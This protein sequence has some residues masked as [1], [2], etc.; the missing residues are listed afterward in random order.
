MNKNITL[1]SIIL[2]ALLGFAV[3]FNSINGKF[4]WDD[5]DLIENNAFIK[6]FSNVTNIFT[7][8]IKI[9]AGREWGFYR[10]IQMLTYM[11]DY[12]LWKLDVRGYHLTNIFLHVFAALAVFWLIN[13]LYDDWLLSSLAGIL[14]V[15]C[16]VHTEAVSYISG[17][18]DSLSLLF[19]LLCFIFY[20][21]KRRILYLFAVLS[22]VTALLSRENS[23]ILPGLL[24]LYHYSFKE[25]IKLGR[26]LPILGVTGIYVFLRL[27]R[28]ATQITYSTTF[29]ERLPGFFAALASYVKLL[30]FPFNLHMEYGYKQFSFSDFGVI[31]G[32]L[33][34]VSLVVYAVR[35]RETNKLVFFSLSWFFINILP[36][37]NLYPINAYMAE[38]WL[39][40][41]SIGFFII[42][43][44]GISF[45]FRRKAYRNFSIVL[46]IGGVSFYSYLTINQNA[47]WREPLSFYERTLKY[48]PASARV[49]NNLGNIYNSM[50][51]KEEAIELYTKAM[52]I[53]PDYAEAYYNLGVVYKD[54]A[55][56][57][58]A[59]AV[60]EKTIELNPKHA[61]AFN[62]LGIV[63]SALGKKQESIASYKAAIEIDPGFAKVYSNLGVVYKDMD[64]NEE[65]VSFYKK[66]I[67]ID[68][69]Y[70]IAHNN[71]AVIYRD[72]KEYEKAVASYREM[73]RINLNPGKAYYNL[74]NIYNTMGKY[75][76]AISAY[77]QAVKIKPD[78]ILVYNNLGNVYNI[79]GKPDEAKLVY[80]KALEIDPNYYEVY[81]NY[82]AM[83]YQQGKYD[84]AVQYY[85]K[86]LKL[87]AAPEEQILELLKPY[88]D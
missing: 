46:V 61:R 88:R 54:T 63:Y 4:I 82:A 42:V 84:L 76:Q 2:I 18:A 5:E 24:L 78:D 55:R 37:S 25:R 57:K 35:K 86:A 52:K 53:S 72:M 9:E 23:L 31:L 6:S 27:G 60:F 66:S 17:R 33:I 34:L 62:N 3:Y 14:F 26:F 38:H 21:K 64:R 30:F 87:G 19:M 75:E 32:I 48:A 71:L 83:Y 49:C 79:L 68:P 11:I 73:I 77:K 69:F 65:A 16:P 22:Y 43:A 40:V 45:L 39:Y 85:D 81:R 51:K 29:L 58:E 41:P 36:V 47:Y 20:V 13:L 1:L 50:D 67:E 10:P 70:E 7:A 44:A 80:D 15:V 12:S 74:G 56:Y 59:I 28:L 8:T